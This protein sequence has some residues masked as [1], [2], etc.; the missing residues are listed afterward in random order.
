MTTEEKL[1]RLRKE[2]REL[3]KAATA[4]A[5]C[6]VTTLHSNGKIGS[7]TGMTFDRETRQIRHWSTQFF[8]ALDMVGIVYDRDLFFAKKKR[9]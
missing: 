1:K 5:K 2:Y 6:A 4:L 7:G 3:K 8:D 9:K